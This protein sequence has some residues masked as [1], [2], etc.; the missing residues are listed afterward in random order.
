MYYKTSEPA[1]QI[2]DG[3]RFSLDVRRSGSGVRWLLKSHANRKTKRFY[4]Y[5]YDYDY[6]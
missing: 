5:D 1:E 6:E 3:F 2:E 4:D